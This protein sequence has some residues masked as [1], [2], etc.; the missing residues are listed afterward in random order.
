MRGIKAKL[1]G[2]EMPLTSKEIKAF[3]LA[4]AD[5][6]IAKMFSEGK[7]IGEMTLNDIEEQV[8]EIGQQFEAALA[9][10]MIRAAE[11]EAREAVIICPERGKEMRHRAHIPHPS[12]PVSR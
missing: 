7:P 11:G 5:V 10:K 3:F 6:V 2:E 9:E 8:M 12:Q 1:R 4:E